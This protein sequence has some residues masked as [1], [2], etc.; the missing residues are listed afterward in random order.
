MKYA[1]IVPVYKKNNKCEKETYRPVRILSN[2]PK[3]Y[4]K[5]MYNRLYDYFDNTVYYF[6]VNEASG[7]GIVLKGIEVEKGI[8]LKG[9]EG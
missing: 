6:Q 9:I 4:E 3:F 7:K 1:D 5:L 2:L 8:V